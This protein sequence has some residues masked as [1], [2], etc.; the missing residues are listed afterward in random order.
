[1]LN[2]KHKIPSRKLIPIILDKGKSI[3][4]PL[5][6][7]KYLYN[8]DKISHFGVITSQKISKKAV[9]RNKIRR[10]IYESIRLFLKEKE[11]SEINIDA[12]ILSKKRLVDSNFET[13]FSTI[14][15]TLNKIL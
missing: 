13:I 12:I 1:M 3:D 8:R 2:K 5:F 14:S 9:V 7:I 11:E 6:A 10:R 15:I 4:T